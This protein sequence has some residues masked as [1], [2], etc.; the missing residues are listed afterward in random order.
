ML[1]WTSEA[2]R[3]GF[4]RA[5][6]VFAPL[7]VEFVRFGAGVRGGAESAEREEEREE[8]RVGLHWVGRAVFV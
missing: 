5:C 6:A 7:D 3:A 2:Q 8:G 4:D 1:P